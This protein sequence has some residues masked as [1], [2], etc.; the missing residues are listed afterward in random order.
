MPQQQ[1]RPETPT[2]DA[3]QSLEM[4]VMHLFTYTARNNGQLAAPAFVEAIQ[5]GIQSAFT[6]DAPLTDPSLTRIANHLHW[7]TSEV[8][9]R[10]R[11]GGA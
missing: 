1:R 8:G 11:R 5:E 4:L 9:M 6:A 2:E 7:L 10:V 3:L